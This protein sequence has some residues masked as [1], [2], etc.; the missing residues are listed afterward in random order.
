MQP[1]ASYVLPTFESEPW[2]RETL[3]SIQHQRIR[4]LEL[5]VIDD[6]S[7]DGTPR[8]L[9]W[10]RQRYATRSFSITILRT[11]KRKGAA[12][13][14][15]RG[16]KL[17]RAPVI[18]VTDAADENHRGR[19]RASLDFLYTHPHLDIVSTGVISIDVMG[20][21]VREDYPHTFHGLP[22]EKPSISHPTV[23]YRRN[24]AYE[25]P[26][27]EGNVDTDQYEAFLMEAARCGHRFGVIPKMF[28]KK[29]WMPEYGGFRD[30]RNARVQKR[31]NYQEFGITVPEFLLDEQLDATIQAE[32]AHEVMV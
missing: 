29:R 15:N 23:A 16:N 14:R 7:T 17:A 6:S 5:I 25:H 8:L 4:P 28:V 32:K 22:G 13:C 11:P 12:F 27:R 26:Y 1:K 24:V 2:L 19:T 20:T 9:D 3:D 21:F 18:F 30:I 31:K 10:Y